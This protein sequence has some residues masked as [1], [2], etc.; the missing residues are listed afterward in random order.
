M[1]IKW[2]PKF[3]ENKEEKSK[4]RIKKKAYHP[5]LSFNLS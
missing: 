4:K 3:G 1:Y 5:T 2:N